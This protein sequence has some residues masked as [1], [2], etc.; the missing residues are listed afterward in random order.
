MPHIFAAPFAELAPHAL[1]GILQLRQNVFVLEQECLYADID[2]R[3]AEPATRHVWAETDAGEVVACIR[4]LDDGHRMRIGRVATARDHRGEGLAAQL[5]ARGIELCAGREITLDA[6]A[7][8]EGWY[9]RFGFLREGEEFL[10][11]GIPH[12]PMTR[13]AATQERELG[14]P[15]AQ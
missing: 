2:G 14:R 13:P 5:M 4:V 7:H 15:S 8:L 10:E 6:Q 3:D 9:A 1:H 12:V 11:D